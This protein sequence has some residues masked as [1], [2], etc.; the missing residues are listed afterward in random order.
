MTSWRQAVSSESSI[1]L[2]DVGAPGLFPI[3]VYMDHLPG[4]LRDAIEGLAYFQQ[5]SIELSTACVLGVLSI[6]ASPFRKVRLPHGQEAPTALYLK[7]TAETSERKSSSIDLLT[8]GVTR[9]QVDL[10]SRY[11]LALKRY[12][13]Q[14]LAYARTLAGAT[15]DGFI[16]EDEVDALAALSPDVPERWIILTNSGSPA[17]LAKNLSGGPG[18]TALFSAEVDRIFNSDFV[19]HLGDFNSYY[20]GETKRRELGGHYGSLDMKDASLTVLVLGQPSELDTFERPIETRLRGTGFLARCLYF[21]APPFPGP[22]PSRGSVELP[23]AISEFND[24]CYDILNSQVENRTRVVAT[25]DKDAARLYRQRA[26]TIEAARQPGTQTSDI[27]DL[28]GKALENESRVAALFAAFDGKRTVITAKDFAAAVDLG[29]CSLGWQRF[30]Y[31][32]SA[33]WSDEE[34]NVTDACRHLWRWCVQNNGSNRYPLSRWN[35]YA[36]DRMRDSISRARIL[37]ILQNRGLVYVDFVT[38]PYSIVLSHQNFPVRPE[39]QKK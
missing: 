37:Q 35:G 29:N 9:V 11:R 24:V 10:D 5:I 13:I 1:S 26:E 33:V 14:K 17:G 34:K 38:R 6:A 7:T 31:G 25:F 27:A 3:P 39:P 8:R 18:T 2:R 4:G 19:D 15:K 23:V 21:H 20:S 12:K 30:R 16:A 36:P 32:A 22:R 28:Y